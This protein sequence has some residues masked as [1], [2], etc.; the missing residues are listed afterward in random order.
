MVCE[1][2]NDKFLYKLKGATEN[3]SFREILQLPLPLFFQHLEPQ[4][5]WQPQTMG[6][7]GWCTATV[8]ASQ[9]RSR[10]Q[11]GRGRRKQL[12]VKKCVPLKRWSSWRCTSKVNSGQARPEQQFALLCFNPISKTLGT[13]EQ[14]LL[15]IN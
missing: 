6:Q 5:R 3:S 1:L 11:A 10:S 14:L 8:R 12:H 9:S 2:G 13:S 15:R 4:Q 7:A